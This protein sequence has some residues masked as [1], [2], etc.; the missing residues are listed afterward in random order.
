M[1]VAAAAPVCCFKGLKTVP[2]AMPK[3]MYHWMSSVM[4]VGTADFDHFEVIVW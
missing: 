1:A 4:V 2:Q 3:S